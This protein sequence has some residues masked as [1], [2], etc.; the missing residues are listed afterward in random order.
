MRSQLEKLLTDTA[1]GADVVHAHSVHSI[2]TTYAAL[3]FRTTAKLIVTPTAMEQ[4]T[5][6]A[7]GWTS[8]EKR[9]EELR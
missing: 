9:R 7:T 1:R 4:A 8:R 5:P 6:P 2:S 3:A